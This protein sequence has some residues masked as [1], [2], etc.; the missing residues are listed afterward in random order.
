MPSGCVGV[1]GPLG[2]PRLWPG[3]FLAPSKMFFR[4]IITSITFIVIMIASTVWSTMSIL[5]ICSKFLNQPPGPINS[6][7]VLF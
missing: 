1:G 7:R 3:T 6:S 4:S 2:S 5:C